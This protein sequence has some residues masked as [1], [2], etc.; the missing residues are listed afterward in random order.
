VEEDAFI[1][2][3]SVI[4][5]VFKLLFVDNDWCV[6]LLEICTAD[7][8]EKFNM[9]VKPSKKSSVINNVCLIL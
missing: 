1:V 8:L 2:V 6:V 3:L 7:A 5:V 9:R 4:G